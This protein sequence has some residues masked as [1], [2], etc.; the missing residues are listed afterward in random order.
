MRLDDGGR[1]CQG[2]VHDRSH[3]LGIEVF[4]QGGGAHRVHE[5]DAQVPE[6]WRGLRVRSGGAQRREPVAQRA[7][8]RVDD[9]LPQQGALRL[10]SL[11]R[12]FQLLTLGGHG[13]Q[14]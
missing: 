3:L 2:S 12:R 5:E 6:G 8:R 7:Q 9:G 11:D 13:G 1:A 4:C 10:Q 14:A